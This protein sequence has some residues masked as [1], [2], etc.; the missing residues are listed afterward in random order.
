MNLKYWPEH[1]RPRDKLIHQGAAAL[2]DTELIAIFLRTGV[3]G[4]NAV[5]LARDLLR[6]FGSLNALFGAPLTDIEAVPGLGPAKF[7]VE[8]LSRRALLEQLKDRDVLTTPDA[9][10]AYLRLRL[11]RHEREVFLVIYVDAQN[12]V[13][14][15]EELFSGTLTQTSVYPRVVVKQALDR[16]AAAVIFAH[17]HPS[18][19]AEP[20]RADELLTRALRDALGLVDIQ[21]LDHLVIGQGEAVSFA[22]RGLI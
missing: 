15:D 6:R 1:D 2:S 7:A 4:K 5:D 21:V 3:A 19:L 9:V 13:I 12:R 16:R 20:S 14:A 18:G 10:K 22:E 17:N 8:E 11:Q